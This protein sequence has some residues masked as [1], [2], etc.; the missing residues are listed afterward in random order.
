MVHIR[1]SNAHPQRVCVCSVSKWVGL[2]SLD[3]E[4]IPKRLEACFLYLASLKCLEGQEA[5]QF[6][7]SCQVV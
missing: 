6:P 2:F 4:G 5:C 3:L 7:G 1:L